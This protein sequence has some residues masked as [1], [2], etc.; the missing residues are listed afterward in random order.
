MTEH[1]KNTRHQLGELAAMSAQTEAMERKILARAQEQLKK[2]E[3]GLDKARVDALAGD[4]E[5]RSR[6]THQIEERGRLQA[7]ISQAEAVLAG[8]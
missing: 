2:I 8:S 4:D 3:A 7:V 1:I 6:Y 5:A